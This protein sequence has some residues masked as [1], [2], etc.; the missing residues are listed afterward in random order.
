M[1]LPGWAV[2]AQRIEVGELNLGPLVA[3]EA[4]R[5]QIT[6]SADIVDPKRGLSAALK[7]SRLDA[8]GGQFT[9]NFSYVP[10]GGLLDMTASASEPAKGLV[11]RLIDMPGCRRWR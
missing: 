1:S 9:A 10:E 2:L 6:G 11:A 5:L 3:G 4:A 7:V 8:P